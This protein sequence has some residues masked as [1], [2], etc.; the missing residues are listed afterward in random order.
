MNV[1]AVYV[2]A[3]ATCDAHA[4]TVAPLQTVVER[5]SNC[6]S[7]GRISYHEEIYHAC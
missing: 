5:G 6:L 2:S 7:F 4:D 1:H 3:T